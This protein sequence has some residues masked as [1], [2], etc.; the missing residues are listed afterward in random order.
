MILYV[1]GY[2]LKYIFDFKEHLFNYLKKN[3]KKSLLSEH[4]IRDIY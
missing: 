1:N 2:F 3:P 4:C